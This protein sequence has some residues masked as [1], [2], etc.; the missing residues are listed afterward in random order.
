MSGCRS[1][2]DHFLLR[3]LL[4]DWARFKNQRSTTAT[5]QDDLPLLER[6][7]FYMVSWWCWLPA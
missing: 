6:R 3:I 2:Q 1:S 4:R 5:P 7:L